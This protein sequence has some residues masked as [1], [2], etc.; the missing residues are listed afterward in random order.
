MHRDELHRFL[1]LHAHDEL[2]DLAADRFGD[3]DEHRVGLAHVAVEELHHAEHAVASLQRKGERAVEVRFVGVFLSAD[4]YVL[5]RGYIR[6]HG[7]A[8]AE[9][10]A[11]EPLPDASGLTTRSRVTAVMVANRQAVRCPTR[12]A[13]AQQIFFTVVS[14]RVPK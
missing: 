1:G 9:R 11:D 7:L 14:W 10:A 12:F 8:F 3:L 6:S 4:A 5:Q 2:A 13:C